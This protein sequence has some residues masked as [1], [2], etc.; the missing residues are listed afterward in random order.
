MTTPKS[1]PLGTDFPTGKRYWRGMEELV[2][3]Q[4]RGPDATPFVEEW[5]RREFPDHAAEWTDPLTRR[6]FLMLMGASL[7]LAGVGGCA[8][9]PAPAKK[10]LPYVRQPNGMVP[11]RALYFAT[12]MTLGGFA[13]GLLVES[14]E[15]RPTKVEGNPQHPASLGATDVFAQASMLGLYDPDRSKT[16]TF[17]GQPRGYSD[18]L[19]ACQKAL[20][21]QRSR[22]GAGI[23]ILTGS[24]T[25]PLLADQLLG[26]RP[27]SF[28]HQFPESRWHQYEPLHRDNSRAGSV[29]AFG[30]PLNCYYDFTHADVIVSLEA[31]FLGTGPAHLR[32]ARQFAI[33][34]RLT[35]A[36]K[37]A[38]MNRLYVVESSPSITGAAADHRLSLPSREIEAFARALARELALR[39][40]PRTEGEKAIQTLLGQ[41]AIQ[42]PPSSDTGL[43]R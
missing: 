7:A 33:R 1:I 17:L 30:E 37:A 2:D 21:A 43:G 32:Y 4:A 26:K 29:L 19:S 25:S 9:Q 10:I 14:H 27:G 15:G 18:V 5:M 8:V 28:A 39:R 16:A 31:D 12:A 40:A 36:S 3:L 41:V 38:L 11:G 6:Q 20:A 13:T 24:T 34:R 42:K 35:D 23:R 22:R